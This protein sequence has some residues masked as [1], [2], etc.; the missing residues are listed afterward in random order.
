MNSKITIVKGEGPKQCKICFVGEAPGKEEVRLGRPFVGP[1]GQ[2]FDS[3]LRSAGIVRQHCYIT[4]VIKEL[5]PHNSYTSFI[6]FGRKGYPRTAKYVEYE[7]SLKA[8]LKEMEANVIVPVGKLA[9]FALTGRAEITKLRGSILEGLDGRK[10]IPILHPGSVRER[11]TVRGA[12]PGGNFLNIYPIT[13]DLKRIR[14]ESNSPSINLPNRHILIDSTFIETMECLAHCKTKSVLTIDIEVLGEE[15]TRMGVAWA[16]DEAISIAFSRGGN[17][18]FLPE[19]ELE[20]WRAVAVLLEDERIVKRGQ[21]IVFD[22]S[23]LLWKYNI[24]THNVDDTMIAQGLLYPDLPKGLDWIASWFTREPYY[25]DEG[26]KWN[27][28]GGTEESFSIY[29]GKD[30]CVTHEAFPK[31]MSDLD[32]LGNTETYKRQVRMVE[33]AVYMQN[34]GIKIDVEGLRGASAVAEE[35]IGVLKEELWSMCGFEINPNSPQ[36]LMNYF[37]IKKGYK[38]YT[39]RGKITTDVNAMKRL[40]RRGVPEANLILKIRKQ[41][42]LRGT[43][44]EVKL[45]E[46]DRIRSNFNPIGSK[47][48]RFSSS[49][50]IF[51]TGMD[52]QNQPEYVRQFFMADEDC[53]IYSLDLEQAENKIVAYISPEPNMIE[54][55]ENKEDIHRKTAGLILNKPPEEVSDEEG[56]YPFGEE[57]WSE[58]KMGKKTNHAFNYRWGYK[59]FALTSGLPERVGKALKDSYFMFYPGVIRYHNWVEADLQKSRKLVNCLG[60]VFYFLDRWGDDLVTDAVAFNPQSTVSDIINSRGL[61]PLYYNQKDFY[62]LDLLCQVHD[63]VLFQI[64]ISL[65]LEYHADCLL[66]LK[67]SLEQPIR[68][69]QTTFTI[70]VGAKMGLRWGKKNMR[71][72]E[73]SENIQDTAHKIKEIYRVLHYATT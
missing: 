13:R 21:N 27:K 65:G 42:K 73:V 57:D 39:T 19:E 72:F 55:F 36:Q 9:C 49:K 23:F 29:N 6:D 22:C 70:P 28:I 60:R 32:E 25:K 4:N 71:E 30:C 41:V 16:D 56:S 14:E 1:V 7:N 59:K 53:I 20:I 68:W 51:D 10:T 46:D 26:K 15:L 18:L 52:L 45:E 37:Y 24:R 11:Q 40:A 54:A 2:E 34:R 67:R 8:E 38:P 3:R 31:I 61:D 44:L 69:K 50:T 47:Y 35:K 17:D 33:P 63:E 64:P 62:G 48:G 12:M 58:R 5:L 66:K 43:Y